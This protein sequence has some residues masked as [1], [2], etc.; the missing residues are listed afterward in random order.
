MSLTLSMKTSYESES[1]KVKGCP[2][3][4]IESYSHLH[5]LLY[6]CLTCGQNPEPRGLLSL[7][8]ASYFKLYFC[9][10]W[11]LDTPLH[12]RFKGI[13]INYVAL[14]GACQLAG[15]GWVL[16]GVCGN[17]GRRTR[18]CE[19]ARVPEGVLYRGFLSDLP[20]TQE[21]HRGEVSIIPQEKGNTYFQARVCRNW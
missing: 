2:S 14:I 19:E 12:C 13:I 7:I 15:S 4:K 8:V 5:K 6:H 16:W 3:V 20:R 1:L 21:G 10:T 11:S 18:N 9:K 17:Q